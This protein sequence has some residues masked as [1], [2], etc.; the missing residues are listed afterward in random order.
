MPI[1]SFCRKSYMCSGSIKNSD[2]CVC[3]AAL[4]KVFWLN[5]RHFLNLLESFN[6]LMWS[7]LILNVV[8]GDHSAYLTQYNYSL[9][10]S[11]K[12]ASDA[13]YHP[14]S[15]WQALL[16]ALLWFLTLRY[17]GDAQIL[18]SLK[19]ED[20]A[21]CTHVKCYFVLNVKSLVY[22]KLDV[23]IMSSC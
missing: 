6:S 20:F 22:Q 4:V 17:S 14:F 18:T 16:S 21:L 1:S 23:L 2:K 8:V 7:A 5:A 13:W 15:I 19:D 3:S 9:R 11:H 12:C 10:R